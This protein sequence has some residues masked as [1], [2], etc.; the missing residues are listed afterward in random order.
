MGIINSTFPIGS[1]ED[2]KEECGSTYIGNEE[3]KVTVIDN[4]KEKTVEMK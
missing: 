2:K 1:S 4:E 3:E